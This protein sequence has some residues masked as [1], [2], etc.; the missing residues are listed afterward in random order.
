MTS[1]RRFPSNDA[2]VA[3]R[4]A[5]SAL[6]WPSPSPRPL[7]EHEEKEEEEE[8]YDEDDDGRRGGRER[9][10]RGGRMESMSLQKTPREYQARC[11]A[12]PR[13]FNSGPS[14][15]GF[16]LMIKTKTLDFL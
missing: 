16:E 5:V 4:R 10:W 3:N 15:D 8:E 12:F 7:E 14:F 11:T 6:R 9:G 13:D 1:V 2:D